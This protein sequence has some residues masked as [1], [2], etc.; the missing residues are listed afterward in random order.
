MVTRRV[1]P[2]SHMM[3][4][5]TCFN[6]VEMCRLQPSPPSSRSGSGGSSDSGCSVSTRS[7]W[8]PVLDSAG[9]PDGHH[10][11]PPTKVSPRTPCAPVLDLADLL[12]GRHGTPQSS[13]SHSRA[14]PALVA[15]VAKHA[16]TLP[17]DKNGIIQLQLLVLLAP[18]GTISG[19]AYPRK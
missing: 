8:T 12:D 10:A 9:N 2:D 18:T 5:Q 4:C 19:I 14:A 17:V 1:G 13:F 15:A 7:S 16:P 11:P 6:L 3:L